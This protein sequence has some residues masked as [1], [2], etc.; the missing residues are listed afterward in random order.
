LSHIAHSCFMHLQCFLIIA[1]RGQF[2]AH[3]GQKEAPSFTHRYCSEMLLSM[4]YWNMILSWW[5]LYY[6]FV[7]L[8]SCVEHTH[9]HTHIKNFLLTSLPSHILSDW[10]EQRLTFALHLRVCRCF[11]FLYVIWLLRW[12]FVYLKD[13]FSSLKL[14]LISELLQAVV[15]LTTCPAEPCVSSQLLW[16]LHIPVSGGRNATTL[17]LSGQLRFS[18]ASSYLSTPPPNKYTREAELNDWYKNNQPSA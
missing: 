5:W 14:E 11:W 2:V 3:S 8:L 17:W 1:T 12:N 15:G 6:I 7:F 18:Q 4:T 16:I 9:T 10:Q 13:S